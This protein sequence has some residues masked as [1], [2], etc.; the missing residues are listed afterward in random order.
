M[1]CRLQCSAHRER[2]VLLAASPETPAH[3]ACSSCLQ[4]LTSTPK[5]RFAFATLKHGASCCVLP[6]PTSVR[7]PLLLPPT[8]SKQTC[9]DD[10]DPVESAIPEQFVT[11]YRAGRWL[12]EPVAHSGA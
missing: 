3:Q 10:A 4:F 1:P 8:H 12:T 11:R 2:E 7:L 9:A 5:H 6:S